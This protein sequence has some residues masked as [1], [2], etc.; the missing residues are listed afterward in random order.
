MDDHQFDDIIK[1]K[2]GEYEESGFDPADLSALHHRMAT[3]STLAWYTRYRTELMVSSVLVVCTL[4]ILLNQWHLNRQNIHVLEDEI[5]VLRKQ[6]EQITTRQHE[7]NQLQKLRRA[8]TIRIVE[9]REQTSPT[10]TVLL[11]RIAVL[12][13]AVRKLQSID[14][15]R[16][17]VNGAAPL[18]PEFM[19]APNEGQAGED[20]QEYFLNP[21]YKITPR[22]ITKKSVRA[23]PEDLTS[24]VPDTDPT[25]RLSV[26]TIRELEKHYQ[27]GVGIRIGP[28]LEISKGFYKNGSGRGDLSGGVLAN[29]IIS[30]SLAVETGVK[31]AHRFYEVTGK[32]KLLNMDLPGVE[33]SLGALTTVDVDSW[34]FEVPFNLKYYYPHSLKT[35]WVVGAGYSSVLYTKQVL[36]YEHEF[37]G[38]SSV[39]VL[40]DYTKDGAQL[41]PGVLNFSIGISRQLKNNKF[42]ETSLYY[43][44]GL[45]P[46]G[47]EKTRLRFVGVRGAYWFRVK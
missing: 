11:N 15:D 32:E 17:D 20:T 18:S 38:S 40:S 3:A 44:H 34:M 41:S 2:V 30:P 46:M 5:L 14:V 29:F 9:I 37:D 36:E 39:A 1:R 45:G 24:P 33:A 26:K 25:G 6:N 13:E 10:Y 43:Q 31:Y 28:V 4:V 12:E 35:D 7:L 42:L 8:D 19:L 23:T 21:S 27:Q 47:V 16:A 22:T